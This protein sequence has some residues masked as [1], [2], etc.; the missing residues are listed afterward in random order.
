MSDE[1]KML[2]VLNAVDCMTALADFYDAPIARQ[3]MRQP[4]KLLNDRCPVDLI[5]EGKG[6]D[7]YS[8]I[9]TMGGGTYL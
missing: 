9:R 1:T 7:V 3:W 5:A 6:A 4:Q 8:L 2:A